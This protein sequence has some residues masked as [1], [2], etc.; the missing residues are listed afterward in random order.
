MAKVRKTFIFN[1]AWAEALSSYTAEV[2]LEIY[3]AI[4]KYASTGELTELRP[5]AEAAFSFIKA[6]IDLNNA[7]GDEISAKRREAGR[8]GNT[9]RWNAQP[10]QPRPQG[11]QPPPQN[12]RY[13]LFG[14]EEVEATP[15]KKPP[16]KHKYTPYVLLTEAEHRK[17]V[18]TYGDDGAE[19]MINKLSNYK[20]ARGMTYKSDYR[21]ILNWVVREYE[22]EKLYGT[23]ATNR[24]TDTTTTAKQQREA[25]FATHIIQKLKGS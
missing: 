13:D 12:I 8:K 24:Q 25:E 4:V 3:D 10:Q 14:N 6:E 18:E 11:S 5:L 23:S 9:V 20:E 22:K 17:L 16:Q 19:W 1:V 2:R 21:A 7:R 15:K